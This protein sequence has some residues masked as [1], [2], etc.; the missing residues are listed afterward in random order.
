MVNLICQAFLIEIRILFI[1]LL[2]EGLVMIL[3][4]LFFFIISF[5]MGLFCGLI[6]RRAEQRENQRDIRMLRFS[7]QVL[8][9]KLNQSHISESDKK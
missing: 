1:E 4:V 6:F 8:R 9:D 5:F 7:N 3:W 2:R